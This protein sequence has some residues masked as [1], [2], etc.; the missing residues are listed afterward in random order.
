MFFFDLT[1]RSFPKDETM[2]KK[3]IDVI[4]SFEPGIKITSS[5]V[6]CSQHFK[7]SSFES[8]FGAR[9][10]KKESIPDHLILIDEMAVENL[11]E[12]VPLIESV[13]DDLSHPTKKRR[14]LHPGDFTTEDM[15]SAEKAILYKE[16]TDEKLK[17]HQ[18]TI[19][20]LQ[21]RNTRAVEKIQ[22]I[23]QLIDKIKENNVLS[24]DAVKVLK[25]IIYFLNRKK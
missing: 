20:N 22:T 3:W 19:R 21:K 4:T 15:R 12:N 13:V 17:S 8:Y 5:S 14:L 2:K 10:L 23:E 7:S 9:H 18:K 16:V 11:K 6:I 24:D 1:L 25:V